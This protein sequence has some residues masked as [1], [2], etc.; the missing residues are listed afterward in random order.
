MLLGPRGTQRDVI[1]K[2]N[3]AVVD[4]LADTARADRRSAAGALGRIGD[5]QSLPYLEAMLTDET[6]VVSNL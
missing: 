1:V 6:Q 2:L 3:G 5:P 4:A